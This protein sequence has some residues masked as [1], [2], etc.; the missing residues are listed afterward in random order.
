[1]D[2]IKHTIEKLLDK[3]IIL[4][5]VTEDNDRKLVKVVVDSEHQVSLNV[6]SSIARAIKDSE[7]LDAR[8]P[9]GYKL[10][11]TSPGISAPLMHPF[12]YRKNIGRILTIA[13]VDDSDVKRLKG[14]LLH[15]EDDGII[16]SGK[17]NNTHSIRFEDIQK[18][19]VKL[20]FK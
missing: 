7:L 4:I 1:M 9:D 13:L 20:T 15:V 19:V 12:Q 8:Y 14:T 5:G 3:E 11:V 6:T 10:E 17:H 2:K 16:L 18:A